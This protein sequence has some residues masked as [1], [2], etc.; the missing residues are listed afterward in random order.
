MFWTGTTLAVVLS[1]M[2]GVE[3]FLPSAVA[4]FTAWWVRQRWPAPVGAGS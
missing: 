4:M 3:M 1:L 2:A